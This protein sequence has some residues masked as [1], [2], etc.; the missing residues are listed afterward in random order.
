MNA[1]SASWAEEPSRWGQSLKERRAWIRR[2]VSSR[3]AM[4]IALRRTR[5]ST[6][7]SR[8][9]HVCSSAARTRTEGSEMT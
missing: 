5:V 4:P 7:V 6:R 9:R 3:S 1:R 8:C 2:S